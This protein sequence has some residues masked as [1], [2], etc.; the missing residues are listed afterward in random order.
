M[1]NHPEIAHLTLARL[2]RQIEDSK[3]RKGLESGCE[4]AWDVW[5][6]MRGVSQGCLELRLIFDSIQDEG[7]APTQ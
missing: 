5:E 2:Q 3:S 7:K 6:S 1:C 4:G